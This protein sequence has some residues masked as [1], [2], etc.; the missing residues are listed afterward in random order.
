VERKEF[1]FVRYDMRMQEKGED[2]N[3]EHSEKT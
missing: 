3:C 1:G 2:K